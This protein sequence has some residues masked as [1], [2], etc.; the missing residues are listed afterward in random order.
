MT[1]FLYILRLLSQSFA[2]ALGGILF[3]LLPVVTVSAVHKVGGAGVMAL[4]SYIPLLFIDMV[5][6]V[7][8]LGFL[9]A[10]VATYGRLAADNEWTAVRMAGIHPLRLLMPA[11]LVAG[12]L[13]LGTNWMAAE[14]APIWKYN[15]RVYKRQAVEGLLRRLNPGRSE[16]DLGSFYLNAH[17]RDPRNDRIFYDVNIA[18]TDRDGDGKSFWMVADVAEFKTEEANDLVVKLKNA[19]II[20]GDEKYMNEDPTIRLPYADLVGKPPKARTRPKYLRSSEL[21]AELGNE[22]MS[23]EGRRANIYEVHR[24]YALSFTYILFLLLGMPT[25]ILMRSGT[26]LGAFAAAVGYAIVYYVLS[27]QF[28]R[29]LSSSGI[30]P[31]FVSPW[32]VNILGTAIGVGLTR[33]VIRK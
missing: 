15:Q 3:I 20:K 19:R 21:L 1:L 17:H 2:F 4:L 6:Y 30:L 10:V 29:L 11:F 5:P 18:Y 14:L 24:R 16:I 27:L 28:G 7:L 32:V 33:K 13:A 9:L 8:P 31:P 22:E 12:L 26:Q 25:G 23:D